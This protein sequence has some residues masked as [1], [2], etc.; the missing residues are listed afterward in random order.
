VIRSINEGHLLRE[1]DKKCQGARDV[2]AMVGLLTGE[3][4]VAESRPTS[5]MS[6]FFGR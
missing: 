1:V 2:E 6:R 5:F 3:E 4:V